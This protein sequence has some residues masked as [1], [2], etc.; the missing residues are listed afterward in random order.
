MYINPKTA[1]QEGWITGPEDFEKYIQPNAIDWPVNRIFVIDDT[2]PF[3]VCEDHKT[4]RHTVELPES[5]INLA[6]EQHP[7]SLRAARPFAYKNEETRAAFW[8]LQSHKVY[9]ISSDFYV[10]IPEGVAAELIIRSTFNRNGIFITSGIYDSGYRGP[11]A[12]CLHNR[13]GEAYIAKGTRIGQ[14]KFIESKSEGTYAGG[15]NVEK[16]KH[17]KE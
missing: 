8:K 10:N 4:H 3:V 5:Y 11:I 7:H 6:S 17:W 14:I 12:G 15:Y 1:I 13:S 2:S 9:D 16:G